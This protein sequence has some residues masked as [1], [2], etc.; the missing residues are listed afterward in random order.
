MVLLVLV[1]ILIFIL[2][3]VRP[4][5]QPPTLSVEDAVEKTLKPL[6]E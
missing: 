4:S 2:G 3:G 6:S 5:A 1:G